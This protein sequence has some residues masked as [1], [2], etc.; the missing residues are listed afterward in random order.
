MS[1]KW[2]VCRA[3]DIRAV[4]G[5]ICARFGCC[6]VR[7][8]R[9]R[10]GTV[11]RNRWLPAAAWAIVP[12]VL[13][14]CSAS[15]DR[16]PNGNGKAGAGATSSGGAGGEDG[17]GGSDNT[18][19]GNGGGAGGAGGMGGSIIPPPVPDAAID[20]RVNEDAPACSALV[21]EN[22]I[23][24]V[25][26]VSPIDLY[27][28]VDKS[29][30]MTTADMLG[31]PSR[32]VALSNAI[33]TFVDASGSD[34]GS[35]GIGMGMAYFPIT[36]AT[37]GGRG[38]NNVSSCNVADYGRA[39]VDIAPLPGN[40]TSIKNAIAAAAPN[41]GTPTAPALQG[42]IQT[43]TAYQAAHPDR[44]VAIVLATDGQPN[45]CN[46]SVPGVA[47]V[48]ASAFA[49]SPPLMTYVLGI[50]TSTGSLDAIA[51]AGGTRSAYMVT[52]S[53]SDQL[54]QA[55]NAI[56]TQTQTQ[57]GTKIACSQ[58]I[59][60]SSSTRPLDYDAAVVTTTVGTA[61]L[62]P[63]KVA[64][65]A[66]CGSSDGWYFDHPTNPTTVVFCPA[67]CNAL[68]PEAGKSRVAVSI[69]CKP[70]PVDPPK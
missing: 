20:A 3:K 11:K 54:L 53:G 48:A 43:A 47:A 1:L 38:G 46:S 35:G 23:I 41:G 8:R 69:P 61:T 32:W 65:L 70:P 15:D 17:R 29:G 33:G 10:G 4:N 27:F 56:R 16:A 62:R 60:P 39:I 68:S 52:A 2:E 66:A 24:V 44:K 42:A 6:R 67:T 9:F 55:L 49:Q 28:M 50:G 51:A 45:D 36:G 22:E 59:P 57:T 18:G 25:T 34:G 58:K 63:P 40:A 19:G 30:S 13:S 37:D 26:T 14:A 5:V 7:D 64:D 12:I 21:D 31:S